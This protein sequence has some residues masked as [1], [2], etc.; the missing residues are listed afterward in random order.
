MTFEQITALLDSHGIYWHTVSGKII[1]QD[2]WLPSTGQIFWA[3][4]TGFTN[5]QMLNFLGY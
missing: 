2:S 1:A 4:V 3:D 5:K